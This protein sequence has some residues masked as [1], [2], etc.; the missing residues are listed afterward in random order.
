MAE[1]QSGIASNV[2]GD[3]KPIV[4]E[5]SLQSRIKLKQWWP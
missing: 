3:D 2:G 4:K 1:T 5:M